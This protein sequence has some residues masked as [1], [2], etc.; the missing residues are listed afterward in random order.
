MELKISRETAQQQKLILTPEMQ[1]SL[2]MLQMPLAEL[3]QYILRA[4]EENP[5][6]EVSAEQDTVEDESPPFDTVMEKI[7]FLARGSE[8]L[9]ESNFGDGPDDGETVDP[10]DYAA[11]K[12]SL[13][14][15]IKEQLLDLDEKKAM[16]IICDYIIENVDEKGYLD[17]TIEDIPAELEAPPELVKHALTRVQNLEPAGVAARELKE[18]LKI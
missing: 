15:F 12:P 17:C 1:Q 7:D 4:L 2:K 6:L 11:V 3:Q 9:K 13:K 8:T 5:V 14:D 16:L 18:Y 10:L